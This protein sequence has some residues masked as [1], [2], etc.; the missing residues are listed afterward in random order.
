MELWQVVGY[1]SCFHQFFLYYIN[2]G[3]LLLLSEIVNFGLGLI[4]ASGK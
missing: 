3:V 4:I 1:D 2:G